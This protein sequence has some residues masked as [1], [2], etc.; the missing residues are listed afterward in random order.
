MHASFDGSI[1]MNETT[2]LE[3][4]KNAYA[5][6]GRGDIP[7][8][9]AMCDPSSEWDVPGPK[10]LPWAGT[11]RGPE[12]AQ[13][14]FATIGAESEVEAFEPQRFVADGDTVIVLG[15]E[16]VRSRRTGRSYS[17]HWAHVFTL[18]NGKIIKYR[19]F[20]DTATAAATFR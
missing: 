11:Y 1:Q 4:I 16:T 12:G 17:T 10:E 9:L 19:P 2:N 18:A 20:Y 3:I 5:A 7:A 6:F 8:I 13:K 14:Y 15:V